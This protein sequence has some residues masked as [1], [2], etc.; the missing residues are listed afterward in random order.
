MGRIK[1]EIVIRGPSGSGKTH[2]THAIGHALQSYGFEVAVID[3]PD[4]PAVLK[5]PAVA[6]VITVL[7]RIGPLRDVTIRTEH[8]NEEL[9]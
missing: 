4:E 2:L 5:S 3:D 8:T 1:L 6:Q 7:R 9:A